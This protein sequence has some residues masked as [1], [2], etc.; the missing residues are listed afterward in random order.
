MLPRQA[1]VGKYHWQKGMR[2]RRPQEFRRVWSHGQSWVH[3]LFVCYWCPN[4]LSLSR[5]GV[6]ASRKVGTAVE[7]NRARRLLREAA[8]HLYPNLR[9]GWDVVLVARAAAHRSHEKEVESVLA[10][11][12]QRAGLWRD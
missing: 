2:L 3:S 5:I 8:R 7:R 11:V 6:T 4:G 12:M 9:L 1:D 10:S